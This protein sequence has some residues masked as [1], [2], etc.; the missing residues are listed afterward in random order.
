LM[1][2]FTQVIA[3]FYLLFCSF[4][5]LFCLLLTTF[6]QLFFIS[7]SYFPLLFIFKKDTKGVQKGYQRVHFLKLSKYDSLLWNI[8]NAKILVLLS[9]RHKIERI[10]RLSSPLPKNIK[11]TRKF[12]CCQPS[13]LDYGAPG[14]CLPPPFFVSAKVMFAQKV[15]FLFYPFFVNQDSDVVYLITQV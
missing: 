7:I 6:L 9:H 15:L 10:S 2:T 1:L 3:Y 14:I 4:F 5:M 11:I 13:G 8:L 12:A